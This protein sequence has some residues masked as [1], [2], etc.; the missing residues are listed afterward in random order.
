MEL[1]LVTINP[2]SAGIQPTST[3]VPNLFLAISLFLEERE[4]MD[5][6]TVTKS[7][8]K[9]QWGLTRMPSRQAAVTKARVKGW[10]PKGDTVG[11]GGR[12]QAPRKHSLMAGGGKWGLSGCYPPSLVA[13]LP[14]TQA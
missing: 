11:G 12:A 5:H 9:K 4:T 13:H 3:P 7:K 14:Y 6:Q 10:G 1:Q 2:A 8:P